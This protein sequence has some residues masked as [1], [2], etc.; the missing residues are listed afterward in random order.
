MSKIPI[1]RKSSCP[2]KFAYVNELDE[3]PRQKK[4]SLSFPFSRAGPIGS[5]FRQSAI[6]LRFALAG[7]P[8]VGKSALLVK[9][10]TGRF[11][12][13]YIKGMY[14]ICM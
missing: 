8:G 4:Y 3:R 12:G 7:A 2:G 5:V 6:F 14:C 10:L 1:S 11:I 13:E 9:F